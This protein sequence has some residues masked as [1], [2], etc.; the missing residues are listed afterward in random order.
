[1]PLNAPE[2]SGFPG[3]AYR[4]NLYVYDPYGRIDWYAIAPQSFAEGKYFTLGRSP[5]CNISLADGSVSAHHAY[6]AAERGEL[7]V[8][9]LGST[10]GVL[11]NDCK[12]AEAALRPRAAARRRRQGEGAGNLLP[13]LGE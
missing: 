13:R 7:F 10:N 8:R 9:D 5:D 1:M 2:D 6:I 4:A 12:M 11:V 3:G